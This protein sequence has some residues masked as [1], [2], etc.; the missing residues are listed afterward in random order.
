VDGSAAFG[1]IKSFRRS[2]SEA[3]PSASEG[4]SFKPRKAE[5]KEKIP[6]LEVVNRIKNP[7]VQFDSSPLI[8]CY[9]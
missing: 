7:K 1:G 8:L 9:F 2:N 4:E 6:L 3:D 5:S